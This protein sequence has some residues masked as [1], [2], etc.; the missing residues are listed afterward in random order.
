MRNW[1][2]LHFGRYT[3]NTLPQIVLHD[4]DYFF[5]GIEEQIFK[6]KYTDQAAEIDYK[7][8][9]IS[10]PKTAPDG[11]HI[12]YFIDRRGYFS[13]FEITQSENVYEGPHF[14]AEQLDLSIIRR[15]KHYDKTGN[16]LML[17]GLK[18]YYFGSA[19][20]RLSKR[21]CE[22]FFDNDNNF[23]IVSSYRVDRPASTMDEAI[24]QF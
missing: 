8:R 13:H 20:V 12:V 7:A 24:W 19:D 4:P 17:R 10:I 14:I 18:Y 15:F 23:C 9:R 16:K 2:I 6:G 11:S 3:G 22:E 21:K 5:W 1:E